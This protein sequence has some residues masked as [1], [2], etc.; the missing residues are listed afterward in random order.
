MSLLGLSNQKVWTGGNDLAIEGFFSW[1]T[2]GTPFSFQYWA[3]G[4]PD[5]LQDS[6]HCVYYNH[7]YGRLW[8]DEN[9]NLKFFF[10]CEM[11]Y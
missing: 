6:Q 1:V 11:R 9:C 2:T 3:N 4:Q 10:L 7:L 8:D 5:N